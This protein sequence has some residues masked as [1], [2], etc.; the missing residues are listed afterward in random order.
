M[1][2]LLI[3]NELSLA[4]SLASRGGIVTGPPPRNCQSRRHPPEV[5]LS[6]RVTVTRRPG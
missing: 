1:V 5:T 2:L 4:V 3:A 6:V